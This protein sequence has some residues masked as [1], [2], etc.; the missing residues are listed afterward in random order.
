MKL[1]IIIVNYNV[2]FYLEQCIRSI[3]KAGK[4]ITH[5][6]IVADNNSND[7]SIAFLKEKFPQ[8]T[9]IENKENLGFAKA[10]NQA[11]R[12]A[13]GEYIMILNPDTILGESTLQDCVMFMDSNPNAVAQILSMGEDHAFVKHVVKI[14]RHPCHLVRPC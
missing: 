10:N 9:F 8:V 1:S 12:M 14:L 13:K 3:E 6:I 7:G 4:N 5:E 11:I 2:K